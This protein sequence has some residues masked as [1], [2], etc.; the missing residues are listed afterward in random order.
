M[1][2]I[3]LT[4]AYGRQY[5]REDEILADWNDGKDF[6]IYQGPYCSVRDTL[7]MKMA[8]FTH[9]FF[10]Y[11]KEDLS[12]HHVSLDLSTYK[13]PEGANQHKFGEWTKTEP[14]T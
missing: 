10:I 9:V 2:S 11:Q 6:K 7:R 12:V 8:N 5:R 1:N 3:Y 14:K 13:P 4:G